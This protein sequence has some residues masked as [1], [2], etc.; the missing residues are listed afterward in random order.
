MIPHIRDYVEIVRGLLR[1]G[2]IRYAGEQVKIDGFDLVCDACVWEFPQVTRPK[3]NRRVATLASPRGLPS[4]A[5]QPF[6]TVDGVPL[7]L[8]SSI[9]ALTQERSSLR[10]AVRA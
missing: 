1:D 4:T 7:A 6:Y 9:A 10:K 2:S 8:Y 5:D 3:H